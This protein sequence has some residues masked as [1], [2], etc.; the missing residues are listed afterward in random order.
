MKI[1]AI[2]D[3]SNDDMAPI[4]MGVIEFGVSETGGVK[5]SPFCFKLTEHGQLIG[6]VCGNFHFDRCF[7][8]YLWVAEDFRKKGL[9]KL[10]LS[11]VKD[12]CVERN[13][14]SILL[15]TIGEKSK[16]V[17]E[18]QGFKVVATIPDYIPGFNQYHMLFEMRST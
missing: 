7:L 12:S 6:G 17:Y 18:S 10:L 5:R 11:A 14:A 3:P 9:G 8:E 13:C 1:T 16:P 2:K 15:Q 4:R